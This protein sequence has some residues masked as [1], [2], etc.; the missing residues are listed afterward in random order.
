[1]DPDHIAGGIVRSGS[2]RATVVATGALL[3]ARHKKVSKE[4]IRALTKLATEKAA[5]GA[6]ED[7][8]ESDSDVDDEPVRQAYVYEGPNPRFRND[9]KAVMLRDLLASGIERFGYPRVESCLG[10]VYLRRGTSRI[11]FDYVILH[12][13][14]FGALYGF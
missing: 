8:H 1:M 10:E 4:E 6:E 11:Y 14:W 5:A 2:H 9:S 13:I 7:A 12:L 3:D